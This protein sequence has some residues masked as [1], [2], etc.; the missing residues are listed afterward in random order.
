MSKDFT[1]ILNVNTLAFDKCIVSSLIRNWNQ[2]QTLT[3]RYTPKYIYT[4]NDELDIAGLWAALCYK[5][6]NSATRSRL[7]IFPFHMLG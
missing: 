4:H 6:N 2:A 5:H 7:I 3:D 1:L